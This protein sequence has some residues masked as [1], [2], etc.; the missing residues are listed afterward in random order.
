MVSS[1][2]TGTNP[3]GRGS[4]GRT[5]TW[6]STPAGQ[7]I[8]LCMIVRDE[9]A[10][11]GRCLDSAMPWVDEV[12]V[13]DTGSTDDTVAIATGRGARLG[14]FSWCDDFAAA[15]NASVD[16][17]TGD[18]VLCLDADEAI[19]AATAPRL[20]DLV[21]GGRSE[22]GRA[23]AFTLVIRSE[24]ALGTT[25]D[26]QA[27]LWENVPG[28]RFRGAIHE[29]IEA[30]PGTVLA[31]ATTTTVVVD[32]LGY[33][34]GLMEARDKLRRN[35]GILSA[36][37]AADPL[38]A[39]LRYKAAQ[40]ALTDG[41]FTTAAQEGEAAVRISASGHASRGPLGTSNLADTFRAL[42][43]ARLSLGDVALAVDAGDR[44]VR[45]CPGHGPLHTQHGLAL[46]AAREP[47]RALV[48][49][50]E[51]RSR[52]E[53][54]LTGAIDRASVGWRALYGM[55]EAYLELGRHA[56]ARTS[57]LQALMDAPG[58]PLVSRALALAEERLGDVQGAYDRLEAAV[59]LQPADSDLRR[60][61]AGILR[62]AGEGA[63][64][65][66]VLAP[67]IDGDVASPEVYD[68][69]ALALD[70]AGEDVDAANAR[71]IARRLREG[72]PPD[73]TGGEGDG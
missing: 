69:L 33:A 71:E 9:A 44:G 8:S 10:L 52:R 38:D 18:W 70:A 39:Y 43:A 60:A 65:V 6:S 48:A 14:H 63:E 27:R 51:A 40:H 32:H 54:P 29:T 57:L 21:V 42:I 12:V 47:A 22:A 64:A 67:L 59:R 50:R 55:G 49:F 26:V 66:R 56:E 15:R 19:T 73:G 72:A 61:L 36:A 37:I 28:L 2:D 7:R 11:L 45:A 1:D 68:D 62:R 41:D 53:A 31:I 13:V 24:T 35:A 17:A 25:E 46:L 16:L 4:S 23:R 3:P 30:S 58:H 5:R 20:R 34:P